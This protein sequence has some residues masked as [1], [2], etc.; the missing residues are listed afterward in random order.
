VDDFFG[1]SEGDVALACGLL[2]R[3]VVCRTPRRSDARGFTLIE[4]MV[5]VAIVAVLA[6]VGV[7]SVRRYLLSAATSEPMEMI[8]SVRAAEESYKDET[9]GY[10]NVGTL[11]SYYPFGSVL[12]ASQKRKTWAGGAPSAD[13]AKWNTL[14][15]Q[16]ST[17]VQFGY[18]CVAGKGAGVPGKSDLNTSI[19]L[20]Y[21]TTAGDWY[22]VRA[23]SD[24]DGNGVAA[25]FVGSSFTDQIYGEN[26][27][28]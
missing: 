21:P 16:A 23:A 14:G 8:N 1:H 24:R 12:P 28:E 20:N 13:E 5:T 10:L 25:I 18:A 15:V 3:S 9:F 11:S 26:E 27:T 4:L 17:V 6:V 22:V 2:R 19:D 7:Y